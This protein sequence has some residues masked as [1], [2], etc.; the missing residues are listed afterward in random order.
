MINLGKKVKE[1][2]SRQLNEILIE[3]IRKIQTQ[4]T[5]QLINSPNDGDTN[6][7][8]LG[9]LLFFDG[10]KNNI[11]NY[12]RSIDLD[13][14]TVNKI[15]IEP[16]KY[17]EY[18]ELEEEEEEEESEGEAKKT[19]NNKKNGNKDKTKYNFKNDENNSDNINVLINQDFN[20]YLD[21]IQK[22]YKKFENNG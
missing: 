16:L 8:F 22:N 5:S 15:Y 10:D 1:K 3:R 7:S 19:N 17:N 2:I 9:G 12:E 21:L 13:K 6:N 14:I 4:N 20:Q 11:L 18:D